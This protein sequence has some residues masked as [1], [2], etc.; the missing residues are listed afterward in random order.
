MIQQRK[1]DYLQRL[2]EEFFK[3]LQLMINKEIIMN[4][5]EKQALLD[6]CFGFFSENLQVSAKN[7]VSEIIAKIPDSDL[8]EQYARLLMVQYDFSA[9]D[10]RSGLSKAFSIV[11]YLQNTDTT[12]S[13]DRTVLRE[14]ILHRLDEIDH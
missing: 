10:D 1:K 3:K 9:K 13:W 7:S 2:I 8:L 5:P 12:Y 14:D 4:D 6:E 11:E